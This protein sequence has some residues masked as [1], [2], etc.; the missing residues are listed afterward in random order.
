MGIDFVLFSL[1]QNLNKIFISSVVTYLYI[2]VANDV[3]NTSIMRQWNKLELSNK[4]RG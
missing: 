4:Q 2:L 3:S 1:R